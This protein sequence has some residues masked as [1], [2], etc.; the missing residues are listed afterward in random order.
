MIKK[1]KIVLT[2][3]Q[4][5]GTTTPLLAG[6]AEDYEWVT[7]PDGKRQ[8]GERIGTRYTLLMLHNEAAPLVVKT[9]ETAPP[10]SPEE[11]AAACLS[12]QFVRVRF[13]NF[14]ATPYQGKNGLGVSATADKCLVVTPAAPSTPAAKS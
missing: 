11:V 4:A 1:L 5:T 14:K 12:G 6:V 7:L 8:P 2:V 3:E 10:I 9:P 13:E